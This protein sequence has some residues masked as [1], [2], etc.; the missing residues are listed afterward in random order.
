ME[1]LKSA[2]RERRGGAEDGEKGA[3]RQLFSGTVADVGIQW[4]WRHKAVMQWRR[5]AR[6]MGEQG[7]A[8]G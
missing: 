1:L 6:G 5:G 8:G 2:Q 7:R 4:R 3:L